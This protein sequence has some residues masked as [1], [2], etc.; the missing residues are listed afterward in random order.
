MRRYPSAVYAVVMRR[1]VR[2]SVRH[3]P[4]LYQG[5]NGRWRKQRLR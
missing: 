1:S 2:A 3:K 5:L 4:V